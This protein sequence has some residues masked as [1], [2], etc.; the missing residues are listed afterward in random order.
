ME[1][2]NQNDQ[3][4]CNSKKKSR[5]R[6]RNVEQHKISLQKSKVQ[7]GLEHTT[8]SGKLVAAK[9]FYEQSECNC[10]NKCAQKIDVH[11]QKV[12]FESF[13]TLESWSKKRLFIRSLV[14]THHTKENFNP[15]T[16]K[17]NVLYDYFL[18]NSSGNQEKVCLVFFLK[19]VQ[20][21]KTT[22]I[23]GD[24]NCDI[25]RNSERQSWTDFS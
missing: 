23:S 3:S 20:T 19:C 21:T 18:T 16:T 17:T 11:R 8:K 25:E 7:G 15:V 14:K 1:N 9:V 6:T 2:I 5:K 12:I 10:K 13:Y 24:E 22:I 4:T